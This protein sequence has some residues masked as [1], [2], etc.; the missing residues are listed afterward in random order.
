MSSP[1]AESAARF[2]TAVPP[3]LGAEAMA[4]RQRLVRQW[5][6][7]SN[8]VHHLRRVLPALC[9]A[10]LLGLGGLALVNTLFS[11]QGVA[12]RSNVLVIRMLKPNFQGRDEK[13]QPY[14][15]T[16]DTAV[17]DDEEPGRVTLM[18]PVFTLGSGMQ[19]THARAKQGVY[20]DDTRILNLTGDVH[21]DGGE[22]YHFVTEHAVIDLRKNNVDGEQHIEGYGPLGRIAASSYAVR[23]G[24]AH[25]YFTGQVKARIEQHGASSG[26][27]PAPVKH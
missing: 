5:R 27:N 6:Q 11:R 12:N 22:G 1:T 19:Q 3:G 4:R 8:R 18:A 2:G 7:H 9:I 13:G 25:A 26:A 24:G 10:M 21:L 14:N 20:R 23:D 17:R 16:A 15:V